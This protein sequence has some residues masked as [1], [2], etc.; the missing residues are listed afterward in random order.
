MIRTI[1]FIQIT[2]TIKLTLSV[3]KKINGLMEYTSVKP[4]VDVA[5][6]VYQINKTKTNVLQGLAGINDMP[7]NHNN[8][9]LYN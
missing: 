9:L 5:E 6:V 8:K 3:S 2:A 7:S 4:N 1:S